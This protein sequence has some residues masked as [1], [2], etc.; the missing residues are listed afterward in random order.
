[1][2]VD[3]ILTSHCLNNEKSFRPMKVRDG[4]ISFLAWRTLK[5]EEDNAE[6]HER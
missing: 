2:R 4:K 6:S 5:L 1:M 3:T